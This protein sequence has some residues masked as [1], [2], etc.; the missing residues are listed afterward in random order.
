[1]KAA[2]LEP[3]LEAGDDCELGRLQLRLRC[4]NLSIV[5]ESRV[6]RSDR[7]DGEL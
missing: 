2:D 1:M 4:V 7:A 5:D 3:Q 6:V